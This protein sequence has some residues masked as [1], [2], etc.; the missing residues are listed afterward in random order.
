MTAEAEPI[1]RAANN[2]RHVTS[3]AADSFMVCAKDSINEVYNRDQRKY[4]GRTK[5][6]A[7]K[8]IGWSLWQALPRGEKEPYIAAARNALQAQA[9]PVSTPRKRR[10]GRFQAGEHGNVDNVCLQ[11]LLNDLSQPTL[12]RKQREPVLTAIAHVLDAVVP[13]QKLAMN[14][15]TA[16]A[17]DFFGII[18]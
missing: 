15:Y 5:A 16:A 13:Q 4:E 1:P 2:A 3:R 18:Q 9:G 14:I 6:Q 8:R 7:M 17:K 12:M 10:K 11:Q